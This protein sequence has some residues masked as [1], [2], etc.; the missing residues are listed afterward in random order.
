MRNAR[1]RDGT[2]S[3]PRERERGIVTGEPSA[4]KD[5]RW[6]RRE[7]AR[8]RPGFRIPEPGT[9]PRSPPCY[10]TCAASKNIVNLILTSGRLPPLHTASHY[11]TPLLHTASH[12]L[13]IHSSSFLAFLA[14]LAALAVLALWPLWPLWPIIHL[15]FARLERVCVISPDQSI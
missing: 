3:L 9:S 15:R 7:A 11:F 12:S 2:G 13:A 14:F 8:K 4:L 1:R 5:A 6:V 10:P